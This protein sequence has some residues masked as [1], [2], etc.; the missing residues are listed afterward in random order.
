MTMQRPVARVGFT[1]GRTDVF[2][3][4]IDQSSIMQTWFDG[5]SWQT[6]TIAQSDGPFGLAPAIYSDQLGKMDIGWTDRASRLWYMSWDG[7]R[8]TAPTELNPSAMTPVGG[9]APVNFGA[10]SRLVPCA[11]PRNRRSGNTEFLICDSK[12]RLWSLS[13]DG[14][15]WTVRDGQVSG[16]PFPPAQVK[17]A[18]NA[19]ASAMLYR[20]LVKKQDFM[21]GVS[22][23]DPAGQNLSA[24]TAAAYGPVLSEP[25]VLGRSLPAGECVDLLWQEHSSELGVLLNNARWLNGAWSVTLLSAQHGAPPEAP[26]AFSTGSALHVLWRDAGGR[27][28]GS[29]DGSGTWVTTGITDGSP[30]DSP[31]AGAFDPTQSRAQAFWIGADG[32]LRTASRG[33]AD[34][35]WTPPQLIAWTPRLPAP[36]AYYGFYPSTGQSGSTGRMD[37]FHGGRDGKLTHASGDGTAWQIETFDGGPVGADAPAIA[38]APDGSSNGTMFWADAAGALRYRGYERPGATRTKIPANRIASPV[39]WSPPRQGM[40]D[41]TLHWINAA[42]QLCEMNTSAPDW[43]DSMVTFG[44]NDTTRDARLISPSTKFAPAP[45]LVP[46]G[47]RTVPTDSQLV[48]CDANGYMFLVSRGGARGQ[49]SFPWNMSAGPVAFQ[50]VAL[51]LHVPSSF[52]RGEVHEWTPNW[53][54]AFWCQQDDMALRFTRVTPQQGF[55]F[56]I[57]PG[58]M[59]TP[60]AVLRLKGGEICVFWGAQDGSLRVSALPPVVSENDLALI[61]PFNYGTSFAPANPWSTEIISPGAIA[62]GSAPAAIWNDALNAPFVFWRDSDGDLKQSWLNRGYGQNF[63]DPAI[64]GAG[65]VPRWQTMTLSADARPVPYTRRPP[66]PPRPVQPDW[67][68]PGVAY[69]IRAEKPNGSRDMLSAMDNGRGSELR[70]PA[71]SKLQ[72]WTFEQLSTG[73]YHIKCVQPF[74][75]GSTF[76]STNLAGTGIGPW[77]VDDDSGRQKWALTRTPHGSFTIAVS[78]GMDASRR[79]LSSREGESTI[80]LAPADDG[81]GLQRWHFAV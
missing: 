15:T 42:N 64:P 26:A 71:D 39:S 55:S 49:Y 79:Y 32:N 72:R 19:G 14:S 33:A 56:T 35:A 68:Q 70:A 63:H 1:P 4:A 58:P 23:D 10:G 48:L 78:G 24:L 76:L 34:A 25:T 44:S 46:A 54:L 52:E 62:S 13:F 3:C 18:T 40:S 8:W 77:M 45:L 2:W 5:A 20:F 51:W 65:R 41:G 21:L 57:D 36:A 16:L 60:P 67:P 22:T 73:L 28:Q 12:L 29:F 53:V 81:S 66:L 80:Y 75:D 9:A 61:S 37:V 47:A 6:Q 43:P 69:R 74:A 30:W 31:A 11:E 17:L 27:L 38:S 7:S 50:P 59:S